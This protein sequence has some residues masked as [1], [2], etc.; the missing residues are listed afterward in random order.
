MSNI[1]RA[2]I[3]FPFP[4]TG[5]SAAVEKGIGGKTAI[6]RDIAAA[7]QGKYLCFDLSSEYINQDFEFK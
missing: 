7:K 3:I 5:T 2:I 4:G 6:K 1:S